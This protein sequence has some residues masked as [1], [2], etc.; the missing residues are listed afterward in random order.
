MLTGKIIKLDK[1]LDGNPANL[2]GRMVNKLGEP[3]V[4]SAMYAA[5]KIM[6][7]QFVLGR[8]MKEALKASRKS[9]ELG[10]THTYDMLGESALTMQDAD[11]YLTDYRNAI[12]AVGNERI[13]D[14]G[15]APSISIKLSA[16]HPR[17]DV[18]NRERVLGE[19]CERLVGRVGAS[20]PRQ[21]RGHQHRCRGDGPPRALP[22]PVR[23]ALPFRCQPR[24]GQARHG[25]AGL[26]QARAAGALLVDR[27]GPR[28]G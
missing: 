20:G 14:G 21:G 16:L 4:R 18:A 3:V 7:K 1:K 28:A 10:Y 17:Y 2:L 19:M 8:D 23:A 22:G 12:E 27:A 24:L 6:G 15:P 25:G 11:K 9:R 13:S 26:L 5:M